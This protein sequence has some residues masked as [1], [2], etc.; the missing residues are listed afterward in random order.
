MENS[1]NEHCL[2]RV[3]IKGLWGRFDIDWTLHPDVNILVGENGMG[4][5]S[6]LKLVAAA[7]SKEFLLKRDISFMGG[8]IH[9]G[10][11]FTLPFHS[12][13][14][15]HSE[16]YSSYAR[17]D[18]PKVDFIETFEVWPFEARSFEQITSLDYKLKQTADKYNR[19]RSGLGEL[20]LSGKGEVVQVVERN[21][22]LTEK[23]NRLFDHTGKTFDSEKLNTY[24]YENL[25]AKWSS[26]EK[27]LL[28]LL[29][30]AFLQDTKPAIL[31]LDL[32]ETSL[33]LRWQHELIE[34]LRRLNPNCQ[35]IIATHSPSI[36]NDGWQDHVFR[37]EDLLKNIRPDYEGRS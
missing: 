3:E 37:M 21:N 12:I 15:R 31:L 34:M 36:F 14:E 26:G 13:T 24:Y 32:P 22:W 29:L 9:V 30:T 7:L 2:K 19:W 17:R 25:Y 35:L 5:S 10:Q 20:I 1:T 11:N 16:E 27:Q 33:S 28:I 18:L 4:K 6:V 23:L 8:K